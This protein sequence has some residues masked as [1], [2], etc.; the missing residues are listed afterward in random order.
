MQ[1]DEARMSRLMAGAQQGDKQ[2]YS[3]LL[4][5]AQVWLAHYYRRRV[6]QDQQSHLVQEV[7]VSL[8]S[9]RA[10]YDP[11]RPFLPWLAAIARYRWIDHLRRHYRRAEEQLEDYDAAED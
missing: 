7:L 6:A 8:H 3:L 10:S 1:A 4:Q 2:A 9:K 11:K 5:D